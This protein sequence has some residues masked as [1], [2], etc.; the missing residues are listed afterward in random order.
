MLRF[1]CAGAAAVTRQTEHMARLPRRDDALLWTG[2]TL[3][4]ALWAWWSW[5][6]SGLSWH[7]FA[8]GAARLTGGSGLAV[9][10]D[11]PELQVGPL[12]LVVAALAGEGDRG[13][14]V[15]E[16][17]MAATGPLL[18]VL[19]A[20]LVTGPHRRLRLALAAV[21]LLPAWS[22]LAVRWG[23]L[24]DVLAML[25]AVL[26]VRAVAAG[27]ASLTGV[28]LGVAIAAKP[29]AVGFLPLVL[30]LERG[31]IRAAATAIGT[32]AVAWLPFLLAAP[33]TLRALRPDVPL[34]PGS[35]LHSLGVRGELVPGWGRTVQLVAAPAV[36]LVVALRA[37]WPG[38]LLAAVAVRLALDPQDNP[39]YVGSAAAAAVVFD[40]VAAGWTV[41]WA[42]SATSVLLW[43]PFVTDY[44]HRL[45]T[46][47]GLAHWWFAHPAAV[48]WVHLGWSAAMVGLVLSVPP[49][50]RARDLKEI[51]RGVYN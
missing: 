7:H 43:Q 24:D 40:L 34:I 22:V 17:A 28:A 23:H 18:L 21:S 38:V 48:G 8:D 42:T 49:L 6:P 19:L 46:T 36:A 33:G 14:V 20:P 13:R 35:G 30:G 2:V 3:W 15:A 29:W 37:A 25:L 9:F 10:A 39:Y 4:A 44:P 16:L 5:R 1:S 50:R 47:S 11:N 12:S 51:P 45:D 26:A 32:T 31:R 27:R 41:P